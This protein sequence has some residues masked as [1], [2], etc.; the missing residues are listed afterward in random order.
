MK[1]RELGLL[2]VLL[3][4]AAVLALLAPGFFAPGNLKNLAL[5]NLP[6]LLAATG[7][8]LVIVAGEID[9]SIGAQFAVAGVLAGV[10]ARLGLPMALVAL[11][12]LALGALF[13]A[14]Q[15]MLVARG[16]PAIVVTL[17]ALAVLRGVLRWSTGGRWIAD[18]PADFQWFGLGQARGQLLFALVAATLV[19][20]TAFALRWLH[21]G[22]TVYALGCDAHAAHL[23]GIRTA[24]VTT[25]VFA[26]MGAF[27]AAAGILSA[28]RYPAIEIEAG[29]GLELQ[30]IACVVLGGASIRGGRGN[31]LGTALGVLL[32]GTLGTALVFLGVGAA[33][34]RAIQGGIILAAVLPELWSPRDRQA[35]AWPSSR[36]AGLEPGGPRGVLLSVLVAEV[37]VFALL[38]ERFAT[39]ANALEIVRATAELGLIALATLAVMKSGGIDLSLGAMMGLAAVTLGASHAAGLPVGASAALA[40]AVGAAGG[41]LNGG[42]VAAGVPPF[43]TTLASLALFRGLAEGWTG[44]YEVYSRFPAGFLQLGQGYLFGFLPPQAVLLAAA[45]VLAWFGLHRSVFGRHVEAVGHAPGAARH[46]GVAVARLSIGLYAL[47]GLCAA[48]AGVLYVAHLG[49]AKADAGSGWELAAITVAVL[50]GTSI[51]GGAGRV[52]GTLL[53]LFCI[54]VL[55]NGLLVTGIPSELASVLL[56]CLLVGTVALR[57][58]SRSLAAEAS[59][60]ASSTFRMRNSQV[61]VLVVAILV[62]AGIIA[63]SNAW[64][65]R[66][67]TSGTLE[68][69]TEHAASGTKSAARVQVALLP[70]NKSDP[71]FASCKQGAEEAARELGLELLWEGPND[72]DAARQNEIVEAWITRGVDVIGVSV[73]NAASISTVLRKARAKGVKVLTWDADADADA[74][75]F[76]V[77]Q[78]TA[79]GIGFGLADEAARVLGG[80]GSFAIVTATLTAAN[81]NAWIEHIRARL[82]SKWPALSI[83]V[84]RPS[85]GLRDK[86]LTETK[87]ILRAH[88]DVKL[89]MVIAAAAVPGAAEAVKQEAS[90]AKVIGLSVPSLCRDYVHEGIIASILLWNTVDLGY[91]TVRAA[92]A[93]ASGELAAGSN[94]FAAGRLG[95]LEVR[96]DNVLL[97][98]PFRFDATNIDRF[99]F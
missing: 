81:Q 31:L 79:E 94:S 67:L 69:D 76:F 88:P 14:G 35:P 32:L 26:A 48:L 83:A 34:E 61:A 74:R 8:T 98:V 78:A 93:L 50:G 82:A 36:N 15:G 39:L 73:E 18:L 29:A 5:D 52:E 84:I 58:G 96:G 72:T 92:A 75:D 49:Q 17:A 42:L 99:D 97:G 45:A 80:K 46:A 77:N 19:L 91:L 59:A 2:A 1:A 23:A 86:A 40:L 3:L 47:A 44:G 6:L 62:G 4:F 64:L 22:R 38:S 70:K 63:L 60:T 41:A 85:D 71:Y 7:M 10:L 28:A 16:V 12:V 56:G 25:A 9:V 54:G 89:V 95:S 27:A 13:G 24:R 43:L 87:A 30:A 33:W 21:V 53:A 65:V 37:A 55:Q 68:G 11:L 51:R 66:S 90:D 57:H 20:L